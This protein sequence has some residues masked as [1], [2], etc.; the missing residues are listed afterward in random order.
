[1]RKIIV[2][3]QS[4]LNG[5]VVTRIEARD[6]ETLLAHAGSAEAIHRLKEV[7]YDKVLADPLLR[8]R[9]VKVNRS[10]SIISAFTVESFGGDDRFTRERGFQHMI[11]VHRHLKM[12][13]EQR[14]R[15]VHLYLA[16]MDEAHLPPDEVPL[17]RQGARRV[18]LESR[19]AEL[20]CCYRGRPAPV[21]ARWSW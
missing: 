10:T 6:E 18:R 12:S 14:R 4:T 16:A 17:G 9:S 3:M 7:F 1:M 2:H 11:D 5:C 20:A 8:P 21:A 19:A 15:F 13:E